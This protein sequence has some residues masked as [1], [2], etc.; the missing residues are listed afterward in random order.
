MLLANLFVVLYC[1][2][3]RKNSWADCQR[4]NYKSNQSN[5]FYSTHLQDDTAGTYIYCSYH[6]QSAGDESC[7]WSWWCYW[8][9]CPN[10]DCSCQQ[11]KP[12]ESIVGC[13]NPT[14]RIEWFHLSGLQL[15]VEQLLRGKRFCLECHK[16]RSQFRSKK[17]YKVNSTSLRM[18][19]YYLMVCTKYNNIS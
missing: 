1:P 17:N 2:L 16:S 8:V 14:C 4:L 3:A 11:D 18:A 6:Q 7:Y 12:E 19:K 13:D 15:T 9:F 5:H 10:E